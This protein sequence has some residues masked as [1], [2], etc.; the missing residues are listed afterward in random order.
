MSNFHETADRLEKELDALLSPEELAR[1][2][3]S[4]DAARATR[5]AP[6]E[7]EAPVM[8][9]IAAPRVPTFDDV[10]TCPHCDQPTD[11]HDPDCEG[12]RDGHPVADKLLSTG[13]RI[14]ALEAERR[15]ATFGRAQQINGELEDLYIRQV[16]ENTGRV[17][18]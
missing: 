9:P 7:A 3:A 16:Y 5:M 6:A 1:I 12:P 2:R 14:A 18:L 4:E 10:E 17:A 11:D 15:G 13:A 8:L